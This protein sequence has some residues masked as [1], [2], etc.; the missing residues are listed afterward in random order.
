MTAPAAAT[1]T[2]AGSTPSNCAAPSVQWQSEAPG[3]SS[4]TAISGATSTT[5]S[6]G[7]TTVAQSGTKYEAVFTNAS[8]STTTNAATLTVTPTTT[9]GAPVVTRVSPNAGWP[10]SVVFV[11]GNNFSH[12]TGVSFGAQRAYFLQIERSCLIA[13]VPPPRTSGSVDVTVTNSHGTS[14]TSSADRFTY[15]G[16]T[17]GP[18]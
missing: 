18:F 10:F 6:T 8:G 3:A 5:L 12:I 13:L 9:T 7:A 1:F 16:R 4:F 2:A 14:A 15:L 17:F 11:C